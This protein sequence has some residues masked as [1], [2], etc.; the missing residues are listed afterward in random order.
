MPQPAFASEVCTPQGSKETH[1]S[2]T[3]QLSDANNDGT[4]VNFASYLNTY[5]TSFS[6]GYWGFFNNPN[7]GVF[8]GT[9][10]AFSSSSQATLV[11]PISAAYQSVIVEAAAGNSLEYDFGSH[12]LAGSV[13]AINFGHGLSHSSTTDSYGQTSDIAMTGLGVTGSGSGNAV[14]NLVYGLMTGNLTNLY[15]LLNANDLT[16]VSSTGD[17]VL[18]GYAGQDT[19]AFNTGSGYDEVYN[20]ADGTDVLDVSGWGVDDIGDLAIASNGAGTFIEHG[21]DFIWLDSVT[22]VQASDFV[23]V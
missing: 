19:F 22:S 4:G 2:F 18:S 8:E 20:F 17:D 6:Q 5:D 11:T 10:Y 23:F 7:D 3:I 13:D 15:S 14:H 9:E 1:M 21:T 16:F 12:V